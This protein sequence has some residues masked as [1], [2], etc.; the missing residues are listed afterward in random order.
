MHCAASVVLQLLHQ[1]Q[2]Q[3]VDLDLELEARRVE[4]VWQQRRVRFTC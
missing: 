1:V 4:L 2:L 3:Q